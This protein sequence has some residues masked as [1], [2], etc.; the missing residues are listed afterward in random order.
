MKNAGLDNAF[1]IEGKA[2]QDYLGGRG[3]TSP[4]ARK[5]INFRDSKEQEEQLSVR[6]VKINTSGTLRR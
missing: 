6:M 1:R 5:K 4:A 3:Y 2:R